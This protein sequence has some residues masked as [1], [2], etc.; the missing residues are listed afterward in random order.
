MSSEAVTQTVLLQIQLLLIMS[1][2]IFTTAN[3]SNS[4]IF[5][6][7]TSANS[8]TGSFGQSKLVGVTD[9]VFYTNG[10]FVKNAQQVVAVDKYGTL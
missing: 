9:G 8:T 4:F 10:L 1:L 2:T 6:N 3:V 7:V 5:E